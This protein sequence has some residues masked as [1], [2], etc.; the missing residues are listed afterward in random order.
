MTRAFSYLIYLLLLLTS[1]ISWA[2]TKQTDVPP[3]P[4]PSREYSTNSWVQ[5][6]SDGGKFKIKFPGKPR[7]YSEM[8][9]G[10]GGRSTVYLAEHN[11]LL[12]YVASYG[13]V[14]VR[15]SD[16]KDFLRELSAMWLDANSARNLEVVKNDDISFNGY[17]GKFLQSETRAIVVRVRWI[18]VKDRVYYQFVAA[19]KHDNGYEKLAMNFL[20]SFEIVSTK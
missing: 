8:Q 20:D 2:Q 15:I 11:G 16:S 9:N 5:Y 1:S 14:K 19:P 12:L 6:V 4:P 18:V 17:P 7:E 3:P 10:P 13:D